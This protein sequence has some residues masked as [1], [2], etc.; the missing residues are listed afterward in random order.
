MVVIHAGRFIMGSPT[1]ETERFDAEGPQHQVDIPFRFALGEY[2]VM[3]AEYSAFTQAT[4][5]EWPEPEFS[6]TDRHPA[7]NVSWYDAQMYVEWLSEKTGLEYRLPSEAEWEYAARAGTTTAR[8]WG[9]SA[10]GAAKYA[11][12][13][14]QATA[15]VGGKKPNAFGLYDVL[16]NV[17]E[18]VE[19]CW[20][21]SYEGAP[22]DGSAWTSGDC[23]RRVLRGS[24]SLEPRFVRS[25]NR[26]RGD[27]SLRFS[28]GGFRVARTLP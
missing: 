1:S 17:W 10:K 20:N 21:E 2:P 27:S 6:Q 23:T 24:W 9:E 3:R 28:Y 19:D 13:D 22:A 26:F 7:V 18:W 8:Y 4:G 15:P 11:H 14:A 16:G 5:R 25:A 12:F